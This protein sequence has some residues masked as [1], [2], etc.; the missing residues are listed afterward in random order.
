MPDFACLTRPGKCIFNFI[1]LSLFLFQY[2]SVRLSAWLRIM[3]TLDL[4]IFRIIDSM[5]AVVA[6]VVAI[7]IGRSFVF[8][9]PQKYSYYRTLAIMTISLAILLILNFT[10]YN[11]HFNCHS[12]RESGIL[13][14]DIYFQFF[15]CSYRYICMYVRMWTTV[16]INWLTI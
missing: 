1:C 14:F 2:K 5:N 16:F 15:V 9:W 4:N 11:Q 6:S 13:K 3:T 12:H 7:A 8:Y 10:I